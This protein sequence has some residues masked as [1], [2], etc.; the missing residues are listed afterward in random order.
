[1]AKYNIVKV[2]RKHRIDL[3]GEGQSLVVCRGK[4]FFSSI[5]A[6]SFAKASVASSVFYGTTAIRC[7][8]N[9]V[10]A[11]YFRGEKRNLM[12]LILQRNS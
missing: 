3:K 4:D 1:M 7:R 2:L 11:R 6:I 12:L 10:C 5:S 8:R 9:Y